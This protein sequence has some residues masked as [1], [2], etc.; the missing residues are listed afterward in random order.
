MD[1]QTRPHFM[2]AEFRPGTGCGKFDAPSFILT[3]FPNRDGLRCC[4]AG[5][6]WVHDPNGREVLVKVMLA[7]FLTGDVV[8]RCERCEEDSTP[9][10]VR[11]GRIVKP[12][13]GVG[14]L[15]VNTGALDLLACGALVHL[16]ARGL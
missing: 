5:R 7:E 2:R 8:L 12:Y 6:C 1:I 15:V 14:A 3:P 11:L 4:W 10:V 9:I 13:T 16:T